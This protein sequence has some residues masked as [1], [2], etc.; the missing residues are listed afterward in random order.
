MTTMASIERAYPSVRAQYRASVLTEAEGICR[1]GLLQNP[2]QA[3]L[4]HS[5]GLLAMRRGQRDFGLACLA[6]AVELVTSDALYLA[7]YADSLDRA[8]RHA[9][10]SAICRRALALAPDRAAS[11]SLLGRILRHERLFDEALSSHEKAE[12][13]APDS[14]RVVIEHAE[15]LETSGRIKEAGEWYQRALLL[16]PENALV[17]ERLGLQ[18]LAQGDTKR[19]DA[20]L[21]LGLQRC[22]ETDALHAG[23]GEVLFRLGSFNQAVDAFLAALALNPFHTGACR[24]LVFGFELLGRRAEAAAAWSSLGA[25]FEHYG[26]LKEAADAYRE[27]LNRKPDNLSS[28]VGLGRVSLDLARPVEAI[29]A[30]RAALTIEPDHAWAHFGLGWA[31][32]VVGDLETSREELDRFF[33]HGPGPRRHFEQPLWNGEPL[34]GRTLLVW[35]D[36]GLGDAVEFLRYLSLFRNLEARI[37]V[38]CQPVLMSLF[39]LLP[40]VDRVVALRTPLPRFDTQVPIGLLPSIFRHEHGTLAEAVPYITLDSRE[41]SHSRAALSLTD[42]ETVGIVWAGGDAVLARSAS[43]MSFAPFSRLRGIRLVSLQVGRHEIELVAPPQGLSVE[44]LLPNDCSVADTAAIIAHLDLVITIDT[45]VAHLAGALGRPVWTLLPYAADWRWVQEGETSSW[46]P[47]MRL[48]RQTRPG[49]WAGVF[50]RVYSAL[51]AHAHEQ[52]HD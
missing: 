20:I 51:Q 15:T 46:Y 26:Q 29:A 21:R 30:Y 14:V 33:R 32:S 7:D 48:F 10:A 41:L 23:L 2:D 18:L 42:D 39:C 49:D 34:D 36:G 9:E 4:L 43:L 24:Q 52:Q 1:S 12:S 3:D 31:T 40:E 5:Y 17:Y 13:L 45:M 11:W 37:V 44:R 50:E 6:R 25:S 22:G 47:S 27:A 38:E 16:S 8:G 19:A 28:L 35:S